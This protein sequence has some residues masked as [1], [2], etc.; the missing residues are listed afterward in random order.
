[1]GVKEVDGDAIGALARHCPN[2]SDL[3]LIDCA[4]IDESKLPLATNLQFL[5]VVGI[6]NV[7]WNA[8]A[9]TLTLK[10]SVVQCSTLQR[11]K[12]F[13]LDSQI[14]CRDWLCLHQKLQQITKRG[15]C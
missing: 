11:R 9:Q 3:G 10:M 12:S 13:L 8:I 6:R 4:I 2:L 15:A 5:S 7:H 1:M 14:S